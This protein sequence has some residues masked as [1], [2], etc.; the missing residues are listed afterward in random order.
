MAMALP[1]P[2]P[3]DKHVGR[4]VRARR[5]TLKMSQTE[6]GLANG[7]TFQQIQKYEKGANR[8]SAS[9]LQQIADILSVPVAFFFEGMPNESK[10]ETQNQR[11]EAFDD[12]L[13]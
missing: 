2:N 7:I 5:L 1:H 4:R 9:R 3:I 8:I 12:F 6:L 13:S 11:S 10:A